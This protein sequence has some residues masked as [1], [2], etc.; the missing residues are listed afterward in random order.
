M[1]FSPAQIDTARQF[2]TQALA[3]KVA[4]DGQRRHVI[5]RTQSALKIPREDAER[6][7]G[8]LMD[9][10]EQAPSP[11]LVVPPSPMNDLRHAEH[12]STDAPPKTVAKP[13]KKAKPAVKKKTGKAA[14]GKKKR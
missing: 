5:D 9:L 2:V 13:R 6:L 3:R 12:P 8:S 1:E 7:V 14:L 11:I 10:T 4:K